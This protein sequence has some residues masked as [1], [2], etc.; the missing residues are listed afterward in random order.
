MKLSKQERIGILVVAVILIIGLGI[1]FF[2]VPKINAANKS[3]A[4]LAT[5]EK[6][7]SEAQSKA[8]RKDD[9]KQQIIDAY[10]EGEDLANMFFEELTPYEADMEFRAFLEQCEANV[11]VESLTVSEA[12]TATLAPE[13]YEPEEVTYD[14]K[15][16]VT[17]DIEKTEEEIESEERWTEIK[18]ALG[19]SQTVGAIT[20]EFTVNAL[21]PAELLKFADEVN[22]YIKEENSKDTRKAV[23]LNG[24][25]FSYPLNEKM[26]DLLMEEIEID[27]LNEAIDLLCKHLGLTRQEQP[28]QSQEEEENKNDPV[29][30]EYIFQLTTSVTFYSVERMQ[31]PAEQLKA[32]EE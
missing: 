1:W 32:Q 15:T 21:D 25:S 13:Y 19:A 6:E 17:Q 31:D 29:P 7:L 14:L 18:T 8:L 10:E 16:Y 3:N 27:A 20:V 9:L 22:H 23:I 28:E 11:L 30:E 12:E 5:K 26:Y 2:I 24:Y 4:T